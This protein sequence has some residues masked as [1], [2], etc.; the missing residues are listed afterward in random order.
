MGIEEYGSGD[1]RLMDDEVLKVVRVIAEK[2]ATFN[3]ELSA[4]TGYSTSKIGT[5]LSDLKRC[6]IIEQIDV[7]WKNADDRLLDR[8]DDLWSR[9]VKGSGNWSQRTWYGLNSEHDWRLK[10]REPDQ[11]AGAFL[12]DEYHQVKDFVMSSSDDHEPGHYVNGENLDEFVF[13]KYD[14]LD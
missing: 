9:G 14:E 2:K 8:R 5:I 3:S 10:T 1:A 13:E 12:V 7:V 4:L 11:L 6:G